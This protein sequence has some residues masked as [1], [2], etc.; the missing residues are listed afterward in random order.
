MNGSLPYGS[1][2]KF[3][4]TLASYIIWKEIIASFLELAIISTTALH[5]PF[6]EKFFNLKAF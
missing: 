1:N 4:A 6:S 2:K 3:Y 5:S